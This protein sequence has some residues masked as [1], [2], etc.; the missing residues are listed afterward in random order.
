[1]LLHLNYHLNRTKKQK[2]CICYIVLTFTVKGLILDRLSEATEQLEGHLSQ[3]GRFFFYCNIASE[4][5]S[6]YIG[7]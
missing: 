4:L 7:S 3:V 5:E 6:L 1:M 2:D